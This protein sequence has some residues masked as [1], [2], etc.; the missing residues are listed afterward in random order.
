MRILVVTPAWNE[1]STIRQV[2]QEVRELGFDHLVIDDGST[3]T[4]YKAARDANALVLRLPLN[5]GVG[6]ALKCAYRFAVDNHYDTVVQVDA[7]GQHPAS[8]IKKIVDWST[9]SEFDLVIGSRFLDKTNELSVS[10]IRRVAMMVLARVSSRYADTRLTDVTSGFR[11]V[12]GGLLEEF[13]ADFPNYYLGDTFEA[14]VIAGRKGY[15]IGEIPVSMRER[16][17][18]TASSSSINSL[19][20]VMKSLILVWIAPHENFGFRVGRAPKEI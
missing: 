6:G 7:D 11:L 1:E 13:A 15:S 2:I 12:R 20:M 4:T 16:Q 14:T 10:T 17:G 8:E 19:I 9:E 18:G 3:D 5:L